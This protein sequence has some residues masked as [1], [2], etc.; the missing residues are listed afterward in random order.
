MSNVTLSEIRR[1]RAAIESTARE[2]AAMHGHDLHPFVQDSWTPNISTAVC[3][4]CG[5]GVSVRLR[6]E[7]QLSGPALTEEC[8]T[9]VPTYTAFFQPNVHFVVESRGGEQH[10][11]GVRFD[12]T[13]SWVNLWQNEAHGV[14]HVEIIEDGADPELHAAAREACRYVDEHQSTDPAAF[15]RRLAD[16]ID[17]RNSC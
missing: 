4:R 9:V 13:Q 7:P 11:V 8:V 16:L 1:E 10:V 17:E 14:P 12:W 2:A 6:D 3:R 15:L 5:K